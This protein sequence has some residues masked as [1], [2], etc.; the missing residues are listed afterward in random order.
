MKYLLFL[1]LSFNVFAQQSIG[2][3]H[4]VFKQVLDFEKGYISFPQDAIELRYDYL[5]DYGLGV[6][7]S[8]SRSTETANS[9]YIENRFYTN[10]VMSAFHGSVF[11]RYK[12]DDKWSVDL[13]VGKASYNTKWT[14]NGKEPSW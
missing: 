13:S 8:V 9:N 1:L 14:V 2:V 6:R 5:T 11:Y 4:S 10:K 7:A 12:L 3:S